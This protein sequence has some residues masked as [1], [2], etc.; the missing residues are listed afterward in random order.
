LLYERQ[1]A[2][3]F[4]CQRYMRGLKWRSLTGEGL[5]KAT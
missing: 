1:Q 5:A 3:C 2:T 4:S